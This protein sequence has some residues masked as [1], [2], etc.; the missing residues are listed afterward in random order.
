MRSQLRCGHW[1]WAACE[2]QTWSKISPG[3]TVR[4]PSNTWALDAL[5]TSIFR[6]RNNNQLRYYESVYRV[7]LIMSKSLPANP[8]CSIYRKVPK[9]PGSDQSILKSKKY[10]NRS[11][12]PLFL[13]TV[14]WIMKIFQCWNTDAGSIHMGDDYKVL[15]L[16][17]NTEG[18]QILFSISTWE[19]S[20]RTK[21]KKDFFSG[22]APLRLL[23]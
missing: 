10:Y 17:G 19:E 8:E 12:Q 9:L 16:T 11:G 20:G 23:D 3:C 1:A 21:E 4:H 5:S 2:L 13:Q 14:P 22:S 15:N 18:T 7:V 6:I